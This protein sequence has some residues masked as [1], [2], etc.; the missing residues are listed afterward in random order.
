M[1]FCTNL[2]PNEIDE[3][4][5]HHPFGHYMKTSFWAKYKAELEGYKIIYTGIKEQGEIKATAIVLKKRSWFAHKPYLYIPTGMCIDHQQ[6]VLWDFFIDNLIKLTRIEKAAFLRIDPNILRCH[7]KINGERVDD[8]FSNEWVSEKLIEKGFYHKGYGYAYNG[9]WINRYTLIIDLS[10][11]IETIYAKFA[12]SKQN[13]LKRHPLMGVTTRIATKDELS[14]LVDFEWE[15]TR[16]QGFKPHDIAFFNTLYSMLG[17]NVRYYVTEVNLAV[18]IANIDKELASNKYKKDQEAQL[19][20]TNERE[21]AL[22]LRLR[23]GENVTIAAGLFVVYGSNCWDLYT[24]NRKDFNSYKATD[25]LHAFVIKDMK[26][27]GVLRYDMVGFSGVVS[28]D[29]PYYGLYDYKR[30]FGSDFYEHIGEFDYVINKK[31]YRYFKT[32]LYQIKRVRR[33]WFSIRYKKNR[34][35]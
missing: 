9:S 28:K 8:G 33:K 2:K 35:E 31:A 34:A 7:R 22:T 23:Y 6:E 19:A 17:E 10:L 1:E 12:R 25:S 21:R 32:M 11:S 15:L 4:V 29:D 16:T 18:Q 30:S 27:H 26:D 5:K 14:Y 3:F 13:V 24:Y 20:K